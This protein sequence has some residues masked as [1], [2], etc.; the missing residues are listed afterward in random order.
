[1]KN[2][3]Y[4]ILFLILLNSSCKAQNPVLDIYTPKVNFKAV[5]GAYYKDTKNVLNGYDGTYLYTN[6]TTSLKIKLQKNIMTSM[7]GAYYEDLVV[8]EYQYI[9]NGVEKVN[10]LS[11]LT[12]TSNNNNINGNLVLTG[13]ELGCKDCRTDEKRLRLG[14][15]SSP[16]FGEIDIRKTT[17]NGKEAILVVFWWTGPIAV[18]EGEPMP[19]PAAIKA[20]TY[21][22][23][24]Q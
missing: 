5:R 16:N 6:G 15:T 3:I 23:V 17:V 14:I 22:M 4:T 8:G 11:R 1:M 18:K 10:T 24:K 12:L 13:K 21:L 7:N 9:E 20:G 2:Y 19:K